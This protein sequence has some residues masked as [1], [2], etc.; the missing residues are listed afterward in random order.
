MIKAEVFECAN[1]ALTDH[2]KD[3]EITDPESNKCPTNKKGEKIFT[4]IAI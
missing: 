4:S 2:L 1:P 3:K